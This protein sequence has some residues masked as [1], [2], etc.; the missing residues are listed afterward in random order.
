MRNE[1]ERERNECVCVV[2][3]DGGVCASESCLLCV[4]AK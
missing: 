2:V 3:V 1:R 4:S